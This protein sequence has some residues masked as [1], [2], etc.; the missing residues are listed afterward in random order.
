MKNFSARVFWLR[1]TRFPRI[2]DAGVLPILAACALNA[3]V[4]A[5][6]YFAYQLDPKM[7]PATGGFIRVLCNFSCLFVPLFYVRALPKLR[8][9][10]GNRALWLWAFFGVLTTSLY[11]ASIPMVGSGMSMFLNAGSGIFIVALA[12]FLTGQKSPLFHWLGVLGSFGGLYLLGHSASGANSAIGSFFALL[13]GLF[14]GLAMLMVARARK[15]YSPESIML[16]WTVANVIAY[17]GFFFFIPPV[18]PTV[19]GA[20][21][22]LILTG[23]AAAGSQYLTAI[24]YQRSSASFVACLSYLTPVLSL[25][26]DAIVFGFS[27]SR[28]ALLG[29]AMVLGF[30]LILPLMAGKKMHG[31]F[32]R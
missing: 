3:L 6:F 20:W 14:G 26:L 19:G 2:D 16:H 9:W 1:T 18:L 28:S 13:S 29:A 32:A 15:N 5:G 7:S 8:P 21:V 12:P 10:H 23:V 24:S 22:V 4:G 31:R 30:G 11:F 27:F 17:A 25:A